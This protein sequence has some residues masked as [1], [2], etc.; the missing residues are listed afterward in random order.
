MSTLLDRLKDLIENCEENGYAP[1]PLEI[2]VDDAG[3]YLLK[4]NHTGVESLAHK[5]SPAGELLEMWVYAT[6]I[7]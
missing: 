6:P 1:F 3:N 4:A 7:T 5:V 2:S